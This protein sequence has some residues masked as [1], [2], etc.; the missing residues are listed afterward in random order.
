MKKRLVVIVLSCILLAVMSACGGG[1]SGETANK[2]KAK[3]KEGKTVVTVSL[4][5]TS[6]FYKAAEKKFEEKYPDIDLQILTYDYQKYVKTVNTVMLSGKGSDIIEVGSLPVGKYVNKKLLLNMNELFEQDNTVP[7]SD[8]YQNILE[9]SKINGGLYAWP[10]AFSLRA[11]V[12]DGDLLVKSGVKVDDAS[13]TWDQFKEVSK[14]LLR[15]GG[16][17][18]KNLQFAM[19]NQDPEVTFQE[20]VIDSFG[21]F[22]DRAA[23]NAKFDS[24]AF[25]DLMQQVK[26]MYA[27]NIVSSAPADRGNQLF[28]STP[29]LSP[30]D[31]IDGPYTFFENPKLLNKP[32]VAGETGGV[33]IIFPSTL[34]IN[35]GSAVKEEAWKF[36]AFLLSEDM[37]TLQEREGFSMLKSVNEKILN[38]IQ[39]QVIKGTYKLPDGKVAKVK[40]ES[41]AEFKQIIE[42]AER[43]AVLDTKVLSI[44]GEESSSFFSGQKSAEEVAK[45]IQ[46]RVTTYLNE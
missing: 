27:D 12:G 44:I 17:S 20:L 1:S 18:N 13:W 31:F 19:A 41:F 21:E 24:P 2:E 30:A 34:A 40:E 32:H 16:A 11:F 3:S 42:K 45:L 38:D 37:Q 25:V 43:Y 9:A 23:Q 29:V 39:D 28:Y 22:V 14:Q 8:L 4:L 15:F 36:L 10:T 33:R 35:A 6:A 46:N 7:K 5:G 26:Q